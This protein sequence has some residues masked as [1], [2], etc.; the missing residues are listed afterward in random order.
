MEGCQCFVLPDKNE[1]SSSLFLAC[2]IALSSLGQTW[3]VDDERPSADEKKVEITEEEGV[4]V[5]NSVNFKEA[6]ETH[7][8]LLVEFYA[9]WCGHCKALAPEYAQAAQMLKDSEH[10]IRLAKVD[11][12]VNQELAADFQVQ[13]YPTLKFFKNRVLREYSGPRE[14]QGIYDWLV[15]KAGPA[16]KDLPTIEAAEEFVSDNAFLSMIGFF[17]DLESVGAK[18]FLKMADLF[19]SLPMGISTDAAVAK[20]YGFDDLGSDLVLFKN[21]SDRRTTFSGEFNESNLTALMN[22]VGV[23]SVPLVVPFNETFAPKVFQSPANISKHMLFIGQQSVDA[24]QEQYKVLEEIALEFR[25]RMFVLTVDSD[26]EKTAGVLE[27]LGVTESTTLPVV[28]MISLGKSA[29]PAK[30]VFD[31][32]FGAD[33]LRVFAAGVLDGTSKPHLDS[34]EQ[35]KDWDKEPVKVLVG[36]TF[37][38]QVIN[39]DKTVFVE[40]YAP[41]CGHCKSLAPTWERLGEYYEDNDKVMIAKIDGTANEVEGVDLEGFPYLILY[42]AGEKDKPV[43]YNSGKRD[44][45]SLKDFVESGGQLDGE[46][47]PSEAMPVQEEE[48]YDENTEEGEVSEQENENARDEL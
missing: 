8:M 33:A 6:V 40:F 19:D 12:T 14:A 43:V 45:E 34:E 42:K 38:E 41:W 20:A 32:E 5:L 17:A 46:P 3:A 30:Y 7:S 25:G 11:A 16:A 29:K 48:V 47:E 37:Q 15:K 24:F 13:G 26:D 10:D 44:Y 18:A 21:F 27:F 1:M 4:L 35:P 28:R 31:G 22:F 9:P 36:K 23:H 2:L 39:S